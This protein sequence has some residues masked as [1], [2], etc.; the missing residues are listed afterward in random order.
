MDRIGDNRLIVVLLVVFLSLIGAL[1]LVGKST[2]LFDPLIADITS[3]KSVETES[4]CGA[5]G[6]EAADIEQEIEAISSSS[7][8]G[9][10]LAGSGPRKQTPSPAEETSLASS[11]VDESIAAKD[12]LVRLIKIVNDE[13]NGTQNELA[14]RKLI[15]FL[16]L[17]ASSNNTKLHPPTV[18]SVASSNGTS[19]QK[20]QQQQQ[21]IF[22]PA[23]RTSSLEELS[24]ATDDKIANRSIVFAKS[25]FKLIRLDPLK[26]S[27]GFSV[28]TKPRGD[29]VTVWHILIN[30]TNILVVQS[31]NTYYYWFVSIVFCHRAISAERRLSSRAKAS[32]K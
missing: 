4:Y 3:N 10:P 12:K 17:N 29:S 24:N 11:D 25:M 8:S 5:S 30:D 22:S 20:F 1:V 28:A 6:K 19:T 21:Q 15:A 27:M 31:I 9:K 14:R 7:S 18:Q 2:D 26:K 16:H 32:E 23:N 13:F